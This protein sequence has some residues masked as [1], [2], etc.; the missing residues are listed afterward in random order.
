[1]SVKAYVDARAYN[2]H[3]SDNNRELGEHICCERA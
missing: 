1:V 2:E 3:G